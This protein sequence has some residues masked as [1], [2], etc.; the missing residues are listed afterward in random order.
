[1]VLL[2]CAVCGNLDVDH[3]P[4]FMS[5]PLMPVRGVYRA[6]TGALL[7]ACAGISPAGISSACPVWACP[8]RAFPSWAV[9]CGWLSWAH[10]VLGRYRRAALSG[11]R[12]R[13]PLATRT[14]QG[15][16]WLMGWRVASRLLGLVN[17]VVLVRLLTPND[18]GLVALA[19][20]FSLAIDSFSY[21]G[22]PDALV[23][24]PTLDRAMYDTGFTMGAL[25]GVL[26]TLVIAGAAASRA[27]LRR[28]EAGVHLSRAGIGPV[29][30]HGGE[31]ARSISSVT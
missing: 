26:T 27:V 14:I 20:S 31:S 13:G 23:R 8:V 22:V 6:M 9:P 5:P 30:D 16:G 15:A 18:F 21:L 4:G 25:R 1:M 12:Q 24:E 7:C 10:L 3:A 28:P 17:T 29:R 19:M 2:H 11:S